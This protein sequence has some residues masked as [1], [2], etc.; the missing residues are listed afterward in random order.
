MLSR[1]SC[2]SSSWFKCTIGLAHSGKPGDNP[3]RGWPTVSQQFLGMAGS[4]HSCPSCQ[5]RGCR[6]PIS[7]LP[8]GAEAGGE[9]GRHQETPEFMARP[10]A[11]GT[12]SQS[13][14]PAGDLELPAAPIESR[15]D[16]RMPRERSSFTQK[17][18]EPENRLA[19]HD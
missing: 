5:V 11:M 10:Q 1:R 3:C 6:M 16:S 2:H 13:N 15:R 12:C 7:P 19:G 9:Q 18:L 14:L 17:C 8:G 4:V